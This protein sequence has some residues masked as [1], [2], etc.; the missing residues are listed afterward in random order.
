[1]YKKITYSQK[2]KHNS[3]SCTLTHG[4]PL[5]HRSDH[6]LLRSFFSKKSLFLKILQERD[7]LICSLLQSSPSAASRGN[8]LLLLQKGQFEDLWSSRK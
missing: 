4:E 6:V 7:S 1:M 5:T 8:T 2:K 3:A